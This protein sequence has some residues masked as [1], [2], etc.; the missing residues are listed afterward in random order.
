MA[1]VSRL[2]LPPNTLN[3]A[4]SQLSSFLHT[5]IPYIKH[6]LCLISGDPSSFLW[7]L[8][9]PSRRKNFITLRTNAFKLFFALTDSLPSFSVSSARLSASTILQLDL[10]DFLRPPTA[11]PTLTPA[12]FTK[13]ALKAVFPNNPGISKLRVQDLF[14]YN[15]IYNIFAR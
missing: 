9:F 4:S 12:S 3:Q 2:V 14:I 10:T 5:S 8:L 11:E 6:G 15:P 7:P 1:M 13:D